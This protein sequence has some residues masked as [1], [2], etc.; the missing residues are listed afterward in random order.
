MGPGEPGGDQRGGGGGC[1]GAAL[2]RLL[3]PGAGGP[4]DSRTSIR[5]YSNQVPGLR[6]LQGGPLYWPHQNLAKSN[7]IHDTPDYSKCQRFSDT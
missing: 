2:H 4:G 5:L 6:F 1:G 3:R 7:M